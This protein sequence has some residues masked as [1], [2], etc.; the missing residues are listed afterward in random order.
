MMWFSRAEYDRNAWFYTDADVRG[1]L[2]WKAFCDMKFPLHSPNE[3][4]ALVVE[5]KT[6]QDRIKLNQQLIHKLEET[7]QAIYKEWFTD[8]DTRVQIKDFGTVVTGKTPSSESPDDFGSETP[9]VTPGDFKFYKKFTLGAERYLSQAGRSKLK[10]KIL[11][12]G[13]VIVTCIGS[14]MGKIAV[15]SENCITNQQMNSIVV[16]HSYYSDYLYY[17]LNDVAEEIKGIAMGGSTMPMLSKSDFEKIELPMPPKNVLVK[18]ESTVMSIN[19]LT[20]SYAK[21][22]KK[23]VEMKNLL[24]AKMA[25][26]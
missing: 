26:T 15:V 25:S 14:D 7:A 10:N 22:I 6:I 18:F 24:L 2:P 12:V 21:E 11:P 5:Y 4:R 3:Q 20:M 19:D 8:N 16:K 23:L 17:Y 9:F 1:G 13:S